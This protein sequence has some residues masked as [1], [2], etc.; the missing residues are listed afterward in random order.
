ME[1]LYIS[2]VIPVF[3]CDKYIGYAIN[4]ILNQTHK[5]NEIII[6]NDGSTDDTSNIIKKWNNKYDFIKII[7][8]DNKGRCE[9][10]NRGVYES[11]N[12]WIARLDAD[13]IWYPDK[14]TKQVRTI[15]EN[16][17]ISL[18]GS[19]AYHINKD[20]NILGLAAE[21][22]KSIDELEKH[23]RKGKFFMI[24]NS[25]ILFR[26]EDFI[27]VGG[28]RKK[29][30]Q[31]ED[32]DLIGRFVECGFKTLVVPEPLV[33]Y[34]RHEDAISV[35]GFFDQR[36]Q[37]RWARACFYYRKSKL[38]EPTLEE[39]RKYLHS[40]NIIKRLNRKRKDYSKYKYRLAGLKYA[41]NIYSLFLINII[42]SFI[43]D[44]LYF[45]NRI[46]SQIFKMYFK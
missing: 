3:N 1:T 35:T 43:F 36:E 7:D 44:P 31:A 45:I 46:Y 11:K 8:Q 40:Q 9:A 13:D 26:K 18:L 15:N 37:Y 10:F 34:R 38:K 23:K 25:S 12:K 24:I 22:P 2:V 29:F 41:E 17:N 27:Y 39:Y 16:V 30:K 33:G 14:I 4:S 28:L 32:F 19:Y 20:G 42:V 21:G 6:V 5:V